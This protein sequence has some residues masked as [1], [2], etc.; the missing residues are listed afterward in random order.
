M[1]AKTL[2]YTPCPSCGRNYAGPGV[3]FGWAPEA[4]ALNP[5]MRECYGCAVRRKAGVN[6]SREVAP[7]GCLVAVLIKE[8]HEVGCRWR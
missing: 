2:R 5:H 1:E 4:L 7:C 6:P 3:S 8:G